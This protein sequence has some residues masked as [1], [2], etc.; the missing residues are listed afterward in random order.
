MEALAVVGFASDSSGRDDE[1]TES[2]CVA[3]RI[4]KDSPFA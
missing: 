3:R 4:K 2:G 1:Q